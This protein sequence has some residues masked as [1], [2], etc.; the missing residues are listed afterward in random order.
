MQSELYD[1]EKMTKKTTLVCDERTKVRRELFP[2]IG[3]LLSLPF[4]LGRTISDSLVTDFR[5]DNL[6]AAAVR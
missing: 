1:G 3:R 5:Y 2:S 6:L 4:G